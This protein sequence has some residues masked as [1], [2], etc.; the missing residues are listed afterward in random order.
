M[1]KLINFDFLP[2]SQDFGLLLLRG[3]LGLSMFFLHGLA[4]FQNFGATVANFR[5]KM[6]IPTVFGACAV[7]AESLCAILLVLG[8][9]T[10]FAAIFLAVTMSV[11]FYKVHDMVLIQTKGGPPSGELALVY[12]GGFLALFFAGAGKFSVD[13]KLLR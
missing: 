10:R 13:A 5:D 1:K 3:W 9:A 7:F 6:G 2:A 11:A 4:K 12:L 8:L